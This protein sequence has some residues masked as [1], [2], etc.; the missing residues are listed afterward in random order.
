MLK[1]DENEIEQESEESS[2]SA[3]NMNLLPPV[4]A[5]NVEAIKK[6]LQ[7]DNPLIYSKIRNNY[8]MELCELFRTLEEK[9]DIEKL[10]SLC[11]IFKCLFMSEDY[12]ILLIMTNEKCIMDIIGALEY[13]TSVV[14]NIKHREFILKKAVFKLIV[15][16]QEETISLIQ[17]TYRLKYLRDVVI[18]RYADD[19][20]NLFF[21][22]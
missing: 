16:L 19:V 15:P 3:D 11:E 5:E 13:D 18:A 21:I 20:S 17:Y 6:L 7:D 8:I 10:H 4:N 12:L 22:F 14:P 9:E 1:K 2:D